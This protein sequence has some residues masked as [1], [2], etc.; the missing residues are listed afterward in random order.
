MGIERVSQASSRHP[1]AARLEKAVDAAMAHVKKVQSR[2]TEELRVEDAIRDLSVHGS[3]VHVSVDETYAIKHDGLREFVKELLA[4]NGAKG[5]R[6]ELHTSPPAEHAVAAVNKAL[7]QIHHR[8]TEEIRVEDSISNLALRDDGSIAVVVGAHARDG[9]KAIL[10][11]VRE[12]LKSA[13]LTKAK[14][15]IVRPAIEPIPPFVVVQRAFDAIQ[16]VQQR[17]TTDLRAEDD[18]VGMH[19]DN[20][21]VRVALRAHTHFNDAQITAVVEKYLKDAGYPAHG[22]VVFV[23]PAIDPIFVPPTTPRPK[24]DMKDRVGI[25]ATQIDTV[26]HRMT[27]EIR[28][29]DAVKSLKLKGAKI[30]VT[31]LSGMAT[32]VDSVK[33]WVK[34]ELKQRHITLPV[35][36]KVVDP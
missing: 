14:L 9:D 23:R 17:L 8:L 35:S 32:D 33:A 29:E 36:F 4:K 13:G 19:L 27:E 15:D 5:V 7:D 31:V 18:I 21:D 1:G 28:I 11:T 25:F 20:N 2:M 22:H 3:E 30:E 12:M 34:D 24:T 6:V 26:H 10:A 16:K